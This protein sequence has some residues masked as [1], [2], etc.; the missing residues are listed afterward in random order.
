MSNIETLITRLSNEAT[1]VRPLQAPAFWSCQLLIVLGV[2]GFITQFLLGI[3][4]DVFERLAQPLFALEILL[5]LALTAS[6]LMAALLAIYPDNHQK[7]RLVSLPYLLFGALVALLLAEL[8]QSSEI[9]VRAGEHSLECALCIASLAVMPS[10]F[11][12]VIL[13]RG[14]TIHPLKA[15]SFAV[16]AASALG[17]L[18]LRLSEANDSLSHLLTW[19]YAPTLCFAA[20]GAWIGRAVLKW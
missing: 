8:V 10:A 9:P 4:H 15:G 13:R 17:C 12:F 19:H 11:L 16:L 7:H 6:S 3:R 18:T 5:L 20:L 1:P 2:Y 14:A